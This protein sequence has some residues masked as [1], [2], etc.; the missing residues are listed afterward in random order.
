MVFDPEDYSQ[1]L[2][3]QS[4]GKS[5]QKVY[6]IISKY[7]STMNKND[8]KMLCSQFGKTIVKSVLKD[9]YKKMYAKGYIST[10]GIDIPLS[11]KFEH[12]EIYKQLMG[13][14]DDC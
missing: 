11:G 14:I 13:M 12:N 3:W 1:N 9:R 8:I 7:L 10:N 6:S 2:F 5:E 4:K